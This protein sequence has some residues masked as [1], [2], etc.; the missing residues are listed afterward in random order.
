MNFMGI[1][2]GFLAET[3]HH[4]HVVPL[5]FQRAFSTDRADRL[6]SR[7]AQD[8]GV[9]V[10][11]RHGRV[12]SRVHHRGGH[13]RRRSRIDAERRDGLDAASSS[14][15]SCWC[16]LIFFIFPEAA[17]D[18]AA[19]IRRTGPAVRLDHVTKAFGARRVLRRCVVRDG[20]RHRLLHSRPQRHGQERHA[21]AHH[22]SAEAGRGQGLR[23]RARRSARLDGRELSRVRRRMGFLFQNAA[24]FD[25]ITR[26]RERRV[27]AAPPHAGLAD[28][29]IR[30]RAP[31]EA[32]S[33][34]GSS[35]STTRCRRTFQAACA[36]AQAWRARWRSTRR[37]CSS[38]SPAP[39]SIRSRPA[40]ST[41]CCC[42]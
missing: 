27:S 19:M 18:E 15:T 30:E 41:S 29:E 36:S 17:A 37:F 8:G 25:S 6:H 9:R 11:H 23:A 26:R 22:R 40:R 16:R 35:A 7:H 1:L 42:G 38:T 10:H 2:G 39:G 4:R 3:R 12:I 13:R 14:S 31:A 32:G 34:S 20:A 21:E 28:G 5:Y 33:R 24:L